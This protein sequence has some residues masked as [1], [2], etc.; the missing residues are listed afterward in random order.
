MDDRKMTAAEKKRIES[1]DKR[2][3]KLQDQISEKRRGYDTLTDEL[4]KL[5]DERHP[6]RKEE[7]VK[8]RLYDAY[9]HSERPLDE[10]LAFMEG[11]DED[12][13]W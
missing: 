9:L 11:R 7:R 12:I 2:I 5:L 1:L 10:I 13:D 8:S 3:E 6:E 4:Q